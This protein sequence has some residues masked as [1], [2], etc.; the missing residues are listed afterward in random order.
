M[1]AVQ[2]CKRIRQ[3]ID[4][5][6]K[7]YGE[8]HSV[9]TRALNI[10]LENDEL[11]TVL[12]NGKA[13]SPNSILLNKKVSFCDL[14]LFQGLDM[15]ISEKQI[16][17]NNIKLNIGLTNTK[18]W[19]AA[20]RF[21]YKKATVF[22][23]LDRLKVMENLILRHG[24][25]EG[26]APILFNAGKINEDY[27]LFSHINAE[28]NQYSIFIIH[29]LLK[30]LDDVSCYQIDRI[31]NS[32][33]Q[34]IGFGPGLTPSMDD[35]ISGLMLSLIYLSHYFSLDENKVLQLNKTIVNTALNKT[36]RVS[37]EMLKFSATGETTDTN[38]EFIIALLSDS[39]EKEFV[40]KFMNVVRFGETSGTDTLCG[41]YF[42]SRILL[43]EKNKEVFANGGQ[44]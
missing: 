24:K 44:C 34:I 21:S 31:N 25:L 7:I 18:D 5:E 27:K 14:R 29:R 38:R 32:A 3:I 36:T 23:I 19:D 12:S 33:K 41:I 9:Y 22:D 39:N 17:F 8:V 16:A 42:G 40:N 11:I 6:K 1:K 26:I 30:F 28:M 20:P 13:M 10:I 15:A 4:K 2:I 43:N 35:F 37:E